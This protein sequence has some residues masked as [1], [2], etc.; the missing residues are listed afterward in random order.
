MYRLLGSFVEDGY[1]CALLIFPE[2]TTINT[3]TFEKSKGF[4]AETSRPELK[5]L[6]LPR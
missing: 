6:V 4:A 1:E 5:H 3:K 2:G